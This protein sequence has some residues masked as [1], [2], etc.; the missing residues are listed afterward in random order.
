MSSST[1]HC[2]HR[3]C[4]CPSRHRHRC[5]RSRC[6]SQSLLLTPS[7]VAP[8]PS[9]LTFIALSQLSLM[10]LPVAPSLSSTTARCLCIGNGNDAITTRATTPSRR[11]QRRL[12]IGSNDTITTRAVTQGQRMCVLLFLILLSVGDVVH[13]KIQPGDVVYKPVL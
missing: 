1:R 11:R 8:S 7:S 9:L 12:C 4:H 13:H 2:H 6:P 3:H 10:L 5:P